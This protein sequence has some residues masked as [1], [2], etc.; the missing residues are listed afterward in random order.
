VLELEPVGYSGFEIRQS[1]HAGARTAVVMPDLATCPDCLREIGDPTNRRYRYPFTNCTNCGPRF[2]IISALPYDRPYT[3][4]RRF[5]QCSACRREY[6]DPSDRRFHAQPNACPVCGPH[7]ELRNRQRETLASR[8]DAIG[9]A[10]QMVRDGLIVAVKGLGG[11]HLMCDASNGTAVAELRRRKHREEKPFALLMPSLDA[12]RPYVHLSPDETD[13]LRST[14]SPI[15]LAER[16]A[17][18]LLFSDAV[19]NA[20]PYLGVML[21]SNPLHHLFMGLVG[22]PVVATSGN[23]SDEPICIDEDEA[24][25]RLGDL[26]DAFLV[27]DRPILRHADD[28]I[29][30]IVLGREQ[31]LRRARGYAPLPLMVGRELPPTLALGAHLK[32]TVA[33]ASGTRIIVGQHLGDLETVEARNAFERSARDLPGLHGVEPSIVACDLHPDYVSSQ[34]ARKLSPAPV[35]VQHH[36]AHVLASM[37]EHDLEGPVLGVSW[38]G[39]G[40]GT[41]GTIWGGEFLVVEHGSWR[42][43]ATLRSFRLPGG[44]A[45]IKEPRRSALAVLTEILG[46]DVLDRTD[47]ATLTAFTE[48]ERRSLVQMIRQGVRS[49]VTTS[50]GR[51]FDAVASI[52]GIRQKVRHEGQAAMELEW[53]ARGSDDTT[54]YDIPLRNSGQH[55]M[56]DWEPAVRCLLR[57]LAAGC[58]IPSLARRF[59]STLAEGI[60]A[61]ASTVGIPH[62]IV[63]GGCFQNGVLT[64]LTVERLRRA[65]F[66][67]FWHQRIPPND[68]GIS[69]GQAYAAAL[70]LQPLE[71][72]QASEVSA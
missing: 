56:L 17:A 49:P 12:T 11:F 35:T 23:R 47:I 72:T 15:V 42:R 6:D 28:S 44:D 64:T 55:Y 50:A 65:G 1:D 29:V 26:A 52:L 5:D 8:W 62:V 7:V 58:S 51:L 24:A 45:A 67:P 69:A 31:V 36:L 27:H 37:A 14:A 61:A 13:I 46:Q 33:V 66:R 48:A 70:R 71:A 18:S 40:L 38:D 22:R 53:A 2:T 9:Q 41:D 20:N 16:T 25:V 3:T 63:T 30:R 19:P 21:P 68:G 34:F 59:H 4:M 10:A 60:T 57:D 32:S 54:A 39:T 43:A